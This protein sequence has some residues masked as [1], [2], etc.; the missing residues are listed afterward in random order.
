MKFSSFSG[1]LLLGMFFCGGRIFAGGLETQAQEE[2]PSPKAE[3]PRRIADIEVRGNQIVSTNTILSKI[4]SQ[5]GEALVQ[6]AVNEDLKRLYATGFFEDIKMEVEEKPDGYKLVVE[7]VEKPIIRQII[8]EGFTVFKEDKLRKEIKVIEGQILDQ[9]AVKQGVEAIRKLYADKG[10]RFV[11]IQSEVDVNRQTKEATV[12]IRINEGQK[13]K[14]KS[15]RFEGAKAFKPKKLL[16]LMKT[17]KK[18]WF[19]SGVFQDTVFEKDL[20]R[21]ALFYQQEGYLDVKIEPDV[22]PA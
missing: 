13:Y 19:R 14:I 5:K 3:T 17:R 9:K 21:L 6:E 2:A 7:V 20:E 8:L 12:Y 10:F 18:G 15:I 4:K 16:K 1:F 22:G 11:D